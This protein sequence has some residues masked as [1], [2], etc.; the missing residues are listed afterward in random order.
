MMGENFQR[1]FDLSFFF[2]LALMGY[3]FVISWNSAIV[4]LRGI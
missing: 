3:F 4:F 1:F 2:F